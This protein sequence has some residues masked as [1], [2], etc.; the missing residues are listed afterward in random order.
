MMAGTRERILIADDEEPFA[1]RIAAFLQHEGYDCDTVGD[2]AAAALRLER[3]RFDLLVA[4]IHMPG[5]ERLEL[6]RE[7]SL[8]GLAVLL[9]TGAPTLETA[10]ESV[11]LPVVGYLVKPFRLEILK[12][13]IERALG[14]SQ[15]YSTTKRAQE[16]LGQWIAELSSSGELSRRPGITAG[17]TMDA[18]VETTIRNVTE[19][20][21]DLARVT[22]GM[23]GARASE[24]DLCRFFECPRLA[25]WREAV[26][27]TIETIEKTKQSFKSK[28]LGLLR[29]KL[30]LLKKIEGPP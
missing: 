6:I 14:V 23:Q 26:N 11:R 21:L 13:E 8:E 16:R 27:E 12:S 15:I 2:A 19:S 24:V 18:Y 4:D 3:D 25:Q 10:I 22:V 9:I 20:L 30:E 1:R 5:N 29:R 7:G 17:V 28:E